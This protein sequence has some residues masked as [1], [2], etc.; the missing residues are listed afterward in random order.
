MSLTNKQARRILLELYAESHDS[1]DTIFGVLS[2][3]RLAAIWKACQVLKATDETPTIYEP[4]TA[5]KTAAPKS[6]PP[7]GQTEKAG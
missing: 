2:S 4:D 3:T 7:Q 5:K 6:E 1:S